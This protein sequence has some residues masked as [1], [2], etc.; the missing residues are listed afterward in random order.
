ML[1]TFSIR[2]ALFAVLATALTAHAASPQL[3]RILPRGA[4]R[5]TEAELTFVGQRLEDAKEIFVYQPGVTVTKIEQ[6]TEKG[7]AGKQLKVTVKIDPDARLGEYDMRVRTAT[8]ISELKSFWV[9]AL[10]T[11]SEKEPNNEF[12]Q[13]QPIPLNVTVAGVIENEDQDFF[14]V[15][16]KKGQRLTAEVE[17]MRL[18][19][20]AF[21]PFVAILDE[22]RFELATNDDNALL[23]QDACVSIVAP[24]DGRYII[25]VRD[26]AWG[27][28]G[29]A[30]YRMHVGT[31]PRPRIVYPLGGQ[32]GKT[33]SVKF[34]GDVLGPITQDITLPDK[35]DGKFELYCEQDGLV[36]PSPN[37]F[38][39]SDFPSVNEVEPN[40]QPKDATDYRG[41]LPVAFNGVISANPASEGDPNKT[42]LDADYFRFAA[43]K[44]QVLDVNVYARRLRSPLDPILSIYSANG[45]QV[46]SNDDSGGPDSYL[47]F[48]VPADGD[49]MVRVRDHLR[50]AGE[51][52]A[53]RVEITPVKPAVTMT[54]PQ[55]TQ[56]YSQERQAVT[57]PKGNRYATLMRLS[58][59]DVSGPMKLE[60]PDLPAGVKMT[61]ENMEPGVDAVPVLFEADADAKVDGKLVALHAKPETNADVEGGFR[62]TV[63]LV[64]NGNQ[65]SFYTISVDKM[66]VAVAEEA[67]F[68]LQIVEPKVPLV[69][70]GS[71]N[72]KIVA[73][74]KGDFKGPI[75]VRMLFK[76]PGV[77][78]AANVEMPADKTEILYPIN[79]SDGAAAKKWKLVVVG[80][81][82]SGGTV[83]TSSP[84]AG[85]EVVPPFVTA[86]LTNTNVEQ[87]KQVN[88]TADLTVATKWEGPAKVEL[89][90]LPGNSTA[91]EKQITAEDTKVEFPITTGTNTPAAQHK[92][93][94]LRVTVL[95]DGEP[96]VHNIARGGILRVDAPL[97]AKNAPKPATTKP[98][99]KPTK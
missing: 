16:A 15:E 13:P 56:Q 23:K 2:F 77:E 38:R 33:V 31:F 55:Y 82:D 22:N 60:C 63:E 90:G 72:L 53:Y 32:T 4:Q 20:F 99:T 6:P 35:P 9:G 3:V 34:L 39:V 1:K 14:V 21:D 46:A 62:Q 30:Y 8:G 98:T 87:G 79:A 7:Q 64:T 12:K 44:G 67:P 70:G 54:I 86:K 91:P 69:Q 76:P 19:E 41:P 37:H 18:G 10:P 74:R 50:G 97:G 17:G 83:W 25:Q 52:Y 26:S 47:K 85:V 68:T 93:L 57:V 95:K 89:V 40:D 43:K 36:A 88:M 29:N 58:R 42:S 45:A 49:Y 24:K 92:G 80:S 5:G 73:E 78:A 65:A 11:V 28:S 27:G 71:M 75:N 51:Q 84:F 48:T 66:A 96:I 61:V 81:S 59:Q 94:F